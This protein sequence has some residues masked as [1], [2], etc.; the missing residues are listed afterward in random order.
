MAT[1]LHRAL[2]IHNNRDLHGDIAIQVLPNFH[3]YVGMKVKDKSEIG[4]YLCARVH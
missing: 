1:G 4:L 2:K 3:S